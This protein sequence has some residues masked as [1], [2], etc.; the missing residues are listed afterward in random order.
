[1][2][3][4]SII[5]TAFVFSMAFLMS[6]ISFAQSEDRPE[7]KG[8]PTY[9]MLLEE[10]DSN[11]DGKLSAKEVKGPLSKDF[12]KV[13]LDEDGFITEEEF[14]KAPKPKRRERE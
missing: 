10:M 11:E 1:M 12:D 5:S 9:K 3:S 8:P 14:K 4:S 6:N 7:R 2:K 13:D